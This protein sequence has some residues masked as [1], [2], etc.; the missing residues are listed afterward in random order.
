MTFDELKRLYAS[1]KIGRREFLAGAAAVGA[2]GAA[3]SFPLSGAKAQMAKKGGTLRIAMAHG[4]TD[5]NYDPAV[6]NNAF[7]QVFATARN[8]YLTE[9]AAEVLLSPR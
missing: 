1:R 5:D 8:G 4:N 3:S 2:L 6:W 7:A 9:V